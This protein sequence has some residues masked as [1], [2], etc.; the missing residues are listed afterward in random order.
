MLK[1]LGSP[2]Y[3]LPV[4]THCPTQRIFTSMF[5]ADSALGFLFSHWRRSPQIWHRSYWVVIVFLFLKSLNK[6]RVRGN[7]T[8]SL[9][10]WQ[11]LSVNQTV[12]NFLLRDYVTQAGLKLSSGSDHMV[13]SKSLKHALLPLPPGRWVTGMGHHAPFFVIGFKLQF[14][15]YCWTELTS[16]FCW[17]ADFKKFVFFQ[18]LCHCQFHLNCQTC[19]IRSFS[20]ISLFSPHLKKKKRDWVSLC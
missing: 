4:I 10:V 1:Q 19:C 20:I 6:F 16:R 2:G 11:N 7:S 3:T 9:H 12:Q 5:M 8:P 18:G 17:Y 13:W 14:Q 15:L